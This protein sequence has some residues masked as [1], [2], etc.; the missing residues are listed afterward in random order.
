VGKLVKT[1]PFFKE[2]F[3]DKILP[4][5]SYA[6]LNKSISLPNILFFTIYFNIILQLACKTHTWDLVSEF[7]D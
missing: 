2:K 5:D 6:E 7:Q 4:Y 1:S 3:F